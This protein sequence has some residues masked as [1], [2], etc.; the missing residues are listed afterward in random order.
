VLWKGT[1]L[2]NCTIPQDLIPRSGFTTDKTDKFL[3]L[4]TAAK[5]HLRPCPYLGRYIV[6]GLSRERHANSRPSGG[7]PVVSDTETS[8]TQCNDLQF[9]SLIVGCNEVNTMQFQ[10]SCSVAETSSKSSKPSNFCPVRPRIL[11]SVLC[12]SCYKPEG[13]GID[14]QWCHWIFSLTQS[15]RLHY[16]PGVDSVSNRNEYHEYFLGVKAAGA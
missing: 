13:H 4:L 1:Q 11:G 5:P 3:S 2:K 9:Q 10:S 6:T 12:V 8:I 16:G 7:A 14:S 15:F